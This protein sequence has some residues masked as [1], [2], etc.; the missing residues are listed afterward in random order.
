MRKAI[1]RKLNSEITNW[2]IILHERGYINDFHSLNH[3]KLQCAQNGECFPI[4]ELNIHLI[5]C[6]YDIL[7]QNYKY[8]HTIETQAGYRGLLIINGLLP[9]NSFTAL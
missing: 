9:L 1:K 6:S 7:N 5:D 4:L 3:E 8:I 2:V